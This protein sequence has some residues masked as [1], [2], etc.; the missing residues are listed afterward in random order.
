MARVSPT[1]QGYESLVQAYG[2]AGS[3]DVIKARAV[4]FS[5]TGGVVNLTGGKY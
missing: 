2:R 1:N 3:S 4:T 5:E